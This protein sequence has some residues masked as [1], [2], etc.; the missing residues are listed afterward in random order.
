[1]SLPSLGISV[2]SSFIHLYPLTGQSTNVPGALISSKKIRQN[3]EELQK[4]IKYVTA[5]LEEIREA[6]RKDPLKKFTSV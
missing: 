6:Q 4:Q 1:M 2:L 5:L 3:S